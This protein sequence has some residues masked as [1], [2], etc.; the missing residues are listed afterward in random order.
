MVPLVV[1]L[2]AVVTVPPA[3]AIVVPTPLPGGLGSAAMV[4]VGPLMHPTP[5]LPIAWAVGV[6]S[7]ITG[8]GQPRSGEQEQCCC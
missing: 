8:Q 7:A 2:G 6:T 3:V 4:M 5:L 1:L